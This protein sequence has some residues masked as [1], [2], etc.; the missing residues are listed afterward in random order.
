MTKSNR[1]TKNP[2]GRPATTGAGTQ[3]GARWHDAELARIDDWRRGQEDIPSR[4]EAIRRLVGIALD[5]A[6][7]KGR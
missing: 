2:R 4:A 3:V 1:G 5:A 7:K 6:G